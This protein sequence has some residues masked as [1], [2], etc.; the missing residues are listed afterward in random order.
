MTVSFVNKIVVQPAHILGKINL[1]GVSAYHYYF[2]KIM[3]INASIFSFFT[4]LY[5]LHYGKTRRYI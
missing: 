2:Y 4:F 5:F 1:E 3:K